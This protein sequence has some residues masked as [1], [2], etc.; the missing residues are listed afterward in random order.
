MP[1][2]LPGTLLL[3]M[4][5]VSI[6][7]PHSVGHGQI[8]CQ[9]RS[10]SKRNRMA[11]PGLLLTPNYWSRL[12]TETVKTGSILKKKT[13]ARASQRHHSTTGVT[14]A[15]TEAVKTDSLRGRRHRGASSHPL[16]N[17]EGELPPP[18]ARIA[19]S[20][21]YHAI[22]EIFQCAFQSGSKPFFKEYA[23]K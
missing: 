6:P 4:P 10:F 8:N 5:A 19:L 9:D 1:W 23:V 12:P 21:G 17:S 14:H 18:P 20:R 15:P 3:C 7:S 11:K 22:C 13:I 2:V 16:F